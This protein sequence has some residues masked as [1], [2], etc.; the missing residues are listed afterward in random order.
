RRF[1][2][3]LMGSE[4]LEPERRMLGA[5]HVIDYTEEDFTEGRRRYELRSFV[6]GVNAVGSGG[7]PELLPR[8]DGRTCAAK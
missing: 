7:P 4:S 1:L 2:I 3:H 8:T 6:C 5:D